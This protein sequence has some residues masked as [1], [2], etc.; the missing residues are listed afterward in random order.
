MTDK[1]DPAPESADPELLAVKLSAETA[2]IPWS[3]LQRFF[4]QGRAVEVRVGTD[5]IA[6][7]AAMSRDQADRIETWIAEG[8][9]R[10]V[11][12]ER[13]QQWVREDA[14]VWALVVRP[15]VLVQAVSD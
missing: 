7:G 6:V 3:Q 11:P 2:K 10:P 5:L 13:A 15:W 4:A 12:D 9:V 14:L 1:S 8:R